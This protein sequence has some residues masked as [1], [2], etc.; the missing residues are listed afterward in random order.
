MKMFGGFQSQIPCGH[1]AGC[2]AA[3]ASSN[4]RAP[5]EAK[6]MRPVAGWDLSVGIYG[7]FIGLVQWFNFMVNSFFSDLFCDLW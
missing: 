1:A 6:D 5:S 2:D 4:C 7:E 3:A